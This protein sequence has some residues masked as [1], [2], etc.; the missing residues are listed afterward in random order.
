MQA[1][2]PESKTSWAWSLHLHNI[3]LDNIAVCFLVQV[4]QVY[5]KAMNI[6]AMFMPPPASDFH[7]KTGCWHNGSIFSLDNIRECGSTLYGLQH[8]VS[9]TNT[10]FKQLLLRI[11]VGIP[12]TNTHR[13]RTSYFKSVHSHF[14]VKLNTGSPFLPPNLSIR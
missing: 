11:Q 6:S 4:S 3:K 1:I 9:P 12:Y 13:H 8:A 14:W 10:T 2:E 7:M 5:I